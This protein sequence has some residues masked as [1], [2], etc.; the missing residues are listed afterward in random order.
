[1]RRRAALSLAIALLCFSREARADVGPVE[2]LE[3]MYRSSPTLTIVMSSVLVLADVGLTTNAAIDAARGRNPSTGVNVVQT[4]VAA[5][6]AIGF[7]LAP[8]FFDLNDWRPT[9]NLLLVLPAQAW[10]MG[11]TTHAIW[12]QSSHAIAPVPRLGVSMWMGVNWA[13][14]ITALGRLADEAWP[15]LEVGIAGA[16]AGLV[17]TAVGVGRAVDD[18][19]RELEWGLMAGWSGG[20]LAFGVAN[21][22]GRLDNQGAR[23][24]GVRRRSA[25]KPWLTTWEGGGVVGVSGAL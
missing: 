12:S 20:V 22:L 14:T 10:S 2:A 15:P 3:K 11:L 19:P 6:Q 7:S 17:G 21:I 9:E 16:S 5:P 1:M 4:S 18:S 8:F 25:V 24:Y 23:N 13:F